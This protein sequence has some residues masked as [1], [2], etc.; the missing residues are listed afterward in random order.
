MPDID[1]LNHA[2]R[3]CLYRCV[4]D[5]AP[6]A[7]LAEFRDFLRE[8]PEFRDLEVDAVDAAARRML[9]ALFKSEA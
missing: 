3:T 1:R 9:R 7:R 4:G 6:I 8:Q 2:V 5:K